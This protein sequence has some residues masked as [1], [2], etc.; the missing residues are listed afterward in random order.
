MLIAIGGGVPS[1]IERSVAVIANVAV[2]HLRSAA[3][4][5]GRAMAQAEHLGR[6]PLPLLGPLRGTAT[7]L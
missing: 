3:D 2:L 7:A 6:R 5:P 1:R 4:V